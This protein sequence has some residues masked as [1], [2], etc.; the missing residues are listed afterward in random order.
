MATEVDKN[1]CALCHAAGQDKR[2]LMVDCFYQLTEV[3]P[4]FQVIR[5]PSGRDHYGMWICKTCRGRLLEHLKVWHDECVQMRGLPKD[6]DGAP[7]DDDPQRN[8]PV[9]LNG[10]TLMMTKEE[11][12]RFEKYR[13][14]Q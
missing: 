13:Q 11:F 1:L 3:V 12:E 9:R 4:E 7:V 8:I 2:F 10:A 14:Q 5:N 6:S